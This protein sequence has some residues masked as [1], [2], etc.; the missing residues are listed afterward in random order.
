[1]TLF[2]HLSCSKNINKPPNHHVIIERLWNTNTD[3]FLTLMRQPA[4]QGCFPHFLSRYLYLSLTIVLHWKTWVS[5][6]CVV[7]AA[8]WKT[9]LWCCVGSEVKWMNEVV[10]DGS[11]D[12]RVGNGERRHWNTL[13]RQASRAW[14]GQATPDWPVPW[15][16]AP[17]LAQPWPACKKKRNKVSHL[18]HALVSQS[19]NGLC[20]KD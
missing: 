6:A 15:C 1:M 20:W 4:R 13:S 8:A 9:A 10:V 18:P 19:H 5:A 16:Q 7:R 17:Y 3:S 12:G 14:V 2:L 11:M